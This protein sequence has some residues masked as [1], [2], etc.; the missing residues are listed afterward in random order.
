MKLEI[1]SKIELKFSDHI[2]NFHL[3][4]RW[5]SEHGANYEDE[6]VEIDWLGNQDSGDETNPEIVK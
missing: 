6:F 2:S 4:F 5:S 1:Q 3:K